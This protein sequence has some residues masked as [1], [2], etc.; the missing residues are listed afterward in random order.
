MI[1][2]PGTIGISDAPKQITVTDASG[3][4]LDL[5]LSEVSNATDINK[6]D[7]VTV[8]YTVNAGKKVARTI[9]KTQA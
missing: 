8:E 6:N 4:S 2:R 3:K 1:A 5:D 7:K 9:K